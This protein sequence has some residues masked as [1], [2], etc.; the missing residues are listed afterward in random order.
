ML[1]LDKQ[2]RKY[3]FAPRDCHNSLN[4]CTHNIIKDGELALKTKEVPY[5]NVYH[6]QI[7]SNPE[8]EKKHSKEQEETLSKLLLQESYRKTSR[9]VNPELEEQIKILKQMGLDKPR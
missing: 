2:T 4:Q 8:K 1:T 6:S 7:L 3:S 9:K 5:L